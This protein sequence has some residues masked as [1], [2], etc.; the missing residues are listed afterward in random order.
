MSPQEIRD[1][2][3]SEQVKYQSSLEAMELA[4]SKIKEM[5]ETITT[6]D[7]SLLNSIGIDGNI[8]TE[9]DLD[10]IKTDKDYL[11]SINQTFSTFVLKLH[12]YLEAELND[13]N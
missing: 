8:L 11:V 13:S 9:L 10:K 3:I 2:I 7:I 5:K 6:E 4:S 1:K 12:D